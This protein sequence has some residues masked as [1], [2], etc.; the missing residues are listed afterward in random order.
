M[1]NE[2]VVAER[3]VSIF[4]YQVSIPPQGG[5]ARTRLRVAHYIPQGICITSRG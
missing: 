4:N 3:A 5:A 1:E 2:I